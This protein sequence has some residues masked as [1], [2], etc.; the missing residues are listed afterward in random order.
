MYDEAYSDFTDAININSSL[1]DR[2]LRS[3]METFYAYKQTS[4]KK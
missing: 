3:I 4:K 1:E 2:Q